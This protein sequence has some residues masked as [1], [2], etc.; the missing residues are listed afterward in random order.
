MFLSSLAYSEAE[1]RACVRNP[2]KLKRERNVGD[3][4]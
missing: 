4:I 3:Q 2:S 1:P